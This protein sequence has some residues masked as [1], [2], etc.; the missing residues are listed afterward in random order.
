MMGNTKTS[1]LSMGALDKLI[2]ESIV[3]EADDAH[4][5]RR[6]TLE[7]LLK[8]ARDVFKTISSRFED[9]GFLCTGGGRGVTKDAEEGRREGTKLT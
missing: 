9:G 7:D 2:K 1:A 4:S 6:V 3:V 8:V 5:T